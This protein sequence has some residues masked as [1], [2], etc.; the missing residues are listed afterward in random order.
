[1]KS[2]AAQRV[3]HS[4]TGQLEVEKK[5]GKGYIGNICVLS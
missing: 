4:H 2:M 3:A 1:M 5:N